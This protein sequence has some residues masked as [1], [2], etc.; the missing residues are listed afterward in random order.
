MKIHI[1]IFAM[2]GIF[3]NS[4]CQSTL[5]WSEDFNVGL[6]NYFIAQPT[7]QTDADTIKV[8]GKK[9]TPNGQRLL[10]IKY[11][12]DG[13]TISTQTYGN[14]SVFNNK[15][16]DYKFDSSNH[17]YLLQKELLGFYKSKIVLQKYSSDGNLLWVEQIY[18]P[19]DT[20]YTPGSIGMAND[21]TVFFTASKEYDYPYE[22]DDVIN[23][24][25]ISYLYAF[26]TEGNLLWEREFN[27]TTE[28]NHFIGNILIYNNA[29]YLF[30][31][32][33]R[34]IKVD[35]NNNLTLNT[36]GLINGISNVQLT[37]DNNLLITAFFGRYR[38][39]KVNLDGSVIWT[40]DYGTNLP[41][42]VTADEI[43]S[44]IQDSDG[45]IYITGRHY[46]TDY[47]SSNYTN[48]DILTLKYDSNGNLIWENRYEYGGNNADTGNTLI[49]KNGEIYVGGQSQRLGQGTDYDYVV[50]KMN[51]ETG[52]SSG[53]YRYDGLANGNDAVS[54][55]FV[56]DNGNVALTGL[57][58]IN[59]EYDWTTQLLSD[60]IVSVENIGSQ[61]NYQVYPNPATSEEFLTVVGEGIISYAL[62]S[63]IGRTVQHAK[64]GTNDIYRIKLGNISKGMYLLQLKTDKEIVTRKIIVR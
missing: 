45:N 2:I 60:V 48:A 27:P 17:I 41:S 29:A 4:Y 22:D 1:L 55:L 58:F 9:N 8:I 7:I 28:A 32:G 36:T 39:S 15:L 47:G 24:I 13:D 64:L 25:S 54:S 33:S 57:S 14:D 38:M 63:T 12:L 5:L 34:L 50:L 43:N 42:N 19:A 53:E 46:G 16:I 6:S 51:S 30:S 3:S 21:T 23:T 59:S 35:I 31:N 26:N 10:I 62:V 11:N 18:S 44:T 49:L 20:S 61:K 56:F 40:S 52:I 37:N